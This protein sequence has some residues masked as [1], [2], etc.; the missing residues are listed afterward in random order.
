MTLF[1]LATSLKALCLS[2]HIL[3]Y[4]G[5]KLEYLSL[6]G[7][8]FS[9]ITEGIIFGEHIC[10]AICIQYKLRKQHIMGITLHSSVVAGVGNWH[11]EAGGRS[12]CQ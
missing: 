5:L 3:R 7:T 6:R 9:P 1:N 11:V 2:T 10:I 4:W 8:Q 12:G